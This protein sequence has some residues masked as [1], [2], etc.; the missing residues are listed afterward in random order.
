MSW[1]GKYMQVYGSPYDEVAYKDIVS[2]V[3]LNL[4]KLQSGQPLVTVSVI[5]YN[6][7]KHLLACLWALSELKTHYPI[8]IIG[9]DNDSKDRTGD[10]FRVLGIPYYTEFQHSCGYARSCGLSHA[11]GKYHVNIDADT[12]YPPEYIDR[13][14]DVMEYSHDIVGVSGT[15][16]YFP[17]AKQ[18]RMELYIYECVRDVYLRLQ[19][20]KR[21]ELAVRGLVFVYRTEEARKV[22]IRCDIIRGE[23]GILAFGL[24]RYGKIAFLRHRKVRA[25]T[26]YGTIGDGM[27]WKR[28]R[29]R[30]WQVLSKFTTLF[31]SAKEY[32][33]EEH[34]LV[35]KV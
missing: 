7:E 30:V 8:E 33:D 28:F 13:M 23:D 6:E 26:G 22:G 24:R 34:N 19:A 31:T 5:A 32:K 14:I 16:G 3:R 12:L 11:K 10:I 27:L 9:V 29:I 17:N 35:K 4:E 1:Y 25:I 18:S 20:W 15:W 2:Q 21:P